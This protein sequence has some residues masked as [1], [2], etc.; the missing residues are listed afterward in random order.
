[1]EEV[2]KLKRALDSAYHVCL[3][4]RDTLEDIMTTDIVAEDM[5][6]V[7]QATTFIDWYEKEFKI[8]RTA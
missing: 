8:K 3:T 2:T 6:H 5:E 1:M 7:K 4:V